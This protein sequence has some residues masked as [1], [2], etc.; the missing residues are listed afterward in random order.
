MEVAP[1][2]LARF[3]I[4]IK[5]LNRKE[6]IIAI[7][8]LFLA[9]L[10][11]AYILISPLLDGDQP[12]RG[13]TFKEG[14]IGSPRFLNPVLSPGNDADSDIT[15]ILFA[16]LSKDLADEIKI[17]PDKKS[18]NL[19][20]K[21]N[22]EWHDGEKITAD[23]VIFTIRAIQ[24]PSYQS[25]LRFNFQGV[26]IEKIDDRQVK[27][28]LKDIYAPFASTLDIGILPKHI[29]Q[30]ID[31]G[32][33]ALAQA[34]INPVGNGPFEFENLKKDRQGKIESIKLKSFQ[35]Q[36]F[37]EKLEFIFYD[38]KEALLSAF[39]KDEVDAMSYIPPADVAKL[40]KDAKL[41]K[42]EIP[43]YFALFFNTEKLD[44]NTRLTLSGSIDKNEIIK[45]VLNGYG[46]KFGSDSQSAKIPITKTVTIATTDWPELQ[47]T[48]QI[49][50][51]QWQEA[52]INSEIKIIKNGA[53]QQEAIRDRDYEILL[54]GEILGLDPDPFAFWHSSQKKHPGLNLSLYDSVKTDRLLVEAR[55]E[56]DL[57]K[58]EEKYREFYFLLAQDAPA[59]F[60]YNPDYLYVTNNKIKGIN[61]ERLSLP[62]QRF[63]NIENWY[64]K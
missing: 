2:L 25:P 54:F 35:K 48:A 24:D 59:A 28:T 10:N 64:I 44:Q 40:D 39:L 55:Q 49:I 60:L 4:L 12:Q 62:S 16:S 58:R 36:S 14:I 8:F 37:I 61:L 17:S 41:Y 6:K 38:S 30:N 7:S 57:K 26:G 20:L 50:K 22:L 13:G 19:I 45:E 33:F 46:K 47:K 32:S 53:I 52:G 43:R 29:W 3:I 21:D 18:Y 27:F 9:F 56:F 23:D 15:Q 31:S 63:S 1:K 51:N 42:I 34:N 11:L 5:K